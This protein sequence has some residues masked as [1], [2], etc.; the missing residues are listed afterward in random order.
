MRRAAGRMVQDVTARWL[1]HPAQ[2]LSRA[3]RTSM[4]DSYT[5]YR[6]SL[7]FRRASAEWS[8]DQ[9]RDWVLRRLRETVRYA[10]ETTP[11]YGDRLAAAGFDARAEF[12]FDDFARLP[13]LERE[14][15]HAAGLGMRS[16]AVPDDVVRRDATGG[17]TGTP[18]VI[19]TG[20]SVAAMA[21]GEG[22]SP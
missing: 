22:L 20:C 4:R 2:L 21:A 7:A 10:S 8:D 13:V 15:I 18:T 5:V 19:W 3:A 11:F 17:S 16:G 6:R 14:D 12:G 9:K 1:W